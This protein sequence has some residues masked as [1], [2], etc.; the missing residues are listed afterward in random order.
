MYGSKVVVMGDS[1]NL[2]FKRGRVVLTRSNFKIIG[3]P[4]F[5]IRKMV[6]K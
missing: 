4:A 2:V 6:K 5:D 1:Q 3:H